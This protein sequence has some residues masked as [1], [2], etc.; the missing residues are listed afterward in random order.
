MINSVVCLLIRT[1]N[2][3][4]HDV[5]RQNGKKVYLQE[6]RFY[7]YGRT[8]SEKSAVLVVLEICFT[9]KALMKAERNLKI[10]A[11]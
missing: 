8:V 11:N 4:L 2:L 1:T 9:N 3:D 6:Q 10:V 7:L 5:L